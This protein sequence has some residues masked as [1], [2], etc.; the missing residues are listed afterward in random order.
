MAYREMQQAARHLLIRMPTDPKGLVDL[1]M[2]LEKNFSVLPQEVIHGGS[3]QSL[4][5]DLL[6]TSGCPSGRS[7]NTATRADI[8]K[9][10]RRSVRKR[11]RQRRSREAVEAVTGSQQVRGID[12]AS[13]I[14]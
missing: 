10:R 13:R 3:G 8:M 6:R 11:N 2:Y 7:P 1:S 4:A 5:V 12:E 14:W 9:R